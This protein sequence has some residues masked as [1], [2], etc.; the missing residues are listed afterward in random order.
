MKLSIRFKAV[1]PIVD[2]QTEAYKQLKADLYNYITKTNNFPEWK[3]VNYADTYS[4]LSIKK[5]TT[6]VTPAEQTT[7][8]NIIAVRAW[9]NALL[10]ERDRVKVLIFA[11][12]TTLEIR[13]AVDSFVY[14]QPPFNI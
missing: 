5:L 3:Q 9:K 10:A 7:I 8:D 1:I 2:Q 4:E 6:S 14:T 12:T 11:A 13:N